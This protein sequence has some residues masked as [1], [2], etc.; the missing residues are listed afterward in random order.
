VKILF[1]TLSNIGDCILTLPVL[2]SLRQ[3]Y[4]GAEFTCLVPP[5]PREVFAGN[6]AFSDTVIFD[7][8]ARFSD[9][10]KLFLELNRRK[11]DLV[12][13]LRN[14]FFGV[15]LPVLNGKI[16]F[17]FLRRFPRGI[18]HMKERHLFRAGI[19]EFSRQ[20]KKYCSLNITPEDREYIGKIL[21]R[22]DAAGKAGLIVLA[23]GSRSRTKCWD[24]E[25]F[26]RICDSLIRE[27]YLLALA[28]DAQER[29]VCDYL[30]QSCGENTVNFCGRTSISQLGALLEK[31]RL[32]ISN[33]NAVMH[34]GSYLEVPTVAIFGPSDEK[35]YGPWTQKSAVVKKDIFCRPCRKAQCRFGTL[36]C[37]RLIKPSEVLE[38]AR[39]ILSGKKPESA[40]G[41]G[42]FYRRILVT[43]TDRLGDVLLSTPVIKALRKKFPQS[44]IGMMVSPYTRDVLDGNPDLDEV[45]IFDK[46]GVNKGW[47]GIL[48]IAAYLR[49][50][51]FDLA[52]VLHPVVRMHLLVFLAGIPRRLGYNR[53]LGFLLTDR[54]EH[55]KQDGE[56]HESEYALD[57]VRYLKIE[58]SDKSLFM[59]LKEESE[60]WAEEL[61]VKNGIRKDDKLLVIH[62]GASCHSRVW[63]GERF[64]EVAD[65]IVQKYGFKAVIVSGPQ[66]AQRAQA[67]VC[68]MHE[69]VLNLAGKTSVSQLASLLKRSHLFISTD[70]G[71]MHVAS[72]MGVPVITIFGRSQAGLS[73]QRW[74]PLGEKKKILHKTVGCVICLAHDC[75]KDFA[76]LKSTTVRDVLDAADELLSA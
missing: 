31:A 3:K 4:P 13:D 69:A 43:R 6:S 27:G 21:E 39:R 75:R 54:I 65:K 56:K 52:I 51:K 74:G 15:L 67:V 10:V 18:E 30:E 70:S 46:S 9:K 33:D 2:D 19:L 5:R 37:L 11:F 1:I 12:V 73:P 24:K 29:A 34:L 16:S 32:L 50:K 8:H 76:C 14:S 55:S 28:G 71:P 48:G 42:R 60:N 72:T 58:P 38:Q 25:N 68:N 44:Y 40:P 36:D 35:R 66:D 64:A 63:P 47:R 57:L 17:A 62:P 59:P 23:P 53:K 7:K 26:R 61:F 22:K 20:S 45:I 41:S 49:K